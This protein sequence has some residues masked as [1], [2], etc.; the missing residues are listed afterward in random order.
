MFGILSEINWSIRLIVIL[1]MGFMISGCSRFSMKGD[2][3]M[4]PKHA[5]T[6]QN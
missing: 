1:A 3:S 5:S 6:N 2:E 4:V